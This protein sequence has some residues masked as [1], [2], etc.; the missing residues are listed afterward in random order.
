VPAV[1]LGLAVAVVAIMY[2]WWVIHLSWTSTGSTSRWH[3]G[4]PPE[5]VSREDLGSIV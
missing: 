3:A 4:L 5:G 2:G 1:V